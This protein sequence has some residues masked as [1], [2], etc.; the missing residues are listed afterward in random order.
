MKTETSYAL[1]CYISEKNI[2]NENVFFWPVFH[3][4]SMVCTKVIIPFRTE[5]FEQTV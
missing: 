4:R 5:M 2:I 3:L 1:A